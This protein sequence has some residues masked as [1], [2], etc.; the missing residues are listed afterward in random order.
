MIPQKI[1]TKL[2]Q[3]YLRLNGCT[4]EYDLKFYHKILNEINKSSKN[5]QNK[6]DFQLK[7]I[8]NEL[9]IKAQQSG[10]LDDLLIESYALV[11]E[12]AQRVL[13]LH[14]FDVQLIGGIVLHQ[15][16]LAEMQT[17]EGKTLTAVLPAYLNA[18]TRKGVHVLTFNDYL[19]RRDA[20]WMGPIFQF[21]G[22]NVGY[23]QEGMSVAERKKA[24][25]ADITYLIAKE[26]GFDFLRDCLCY[27]KKD[28]VQR[29]FNFAIIDEA[30]SILIDEARIPLVIAA[31]SEDYLADTY[32]MVQIVRNFKKDIDFEIDEYARN[33]FL[34]NS[35]IAHV[36]K[37]LDCDNIHDPKNVNL[38]IRI[39][40]AMHAEFLLQRDV[41]Y[42]V[43][44]NKIELVDE[45]TGRVADR[46]R[47]QAI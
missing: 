47:W 41:D 34:T 24:Y 11:R 4:T 21:L 30:D 32:R 18:L 37:L 14:P 10:V 38:L 25:A 43:R 40:C 42:I 44:N 35:G 36:E 1:Y 8:S 23:I 33:I 13:K 29:K 2:K 46:R 28:I 17:G 22:L 20:N 15:G 39:N 7:K 19:A 12:V 9:S 26:A 16:K 27:H 5:L 31:A 3:L 45:F 6:T